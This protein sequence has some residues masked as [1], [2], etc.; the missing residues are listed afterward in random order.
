MFGTHEEMFLCN[1][2]G[3][4]GSCKVIL[5]ALGIDLLYLGVGVIVN[6]LSFVHFSQV[7]RGHT[8]VLKRDPLRK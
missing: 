5:V 4:R 8:S 1:G 3:G 7:I 2:G 6:T